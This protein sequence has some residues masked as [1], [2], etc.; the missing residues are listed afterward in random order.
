M[1]IT[2][3]GFKTASLLWQQQCSNLETTY[4]RHAVTRHTVVTVLTTGW[5]QFLSP[6]Q[7]NQSTGSQ[8][9]LSNTK[10]KITEQKNWKTCIQKIQKGLKVHKSKRYVVTVAILWPVAWWT[11]HP[12]YAES[13]FR[14]T[15]VFKK[16]KPTGFLGLYWVLGF[17]GYLW[18]YL[19]EQLG[20][21]LVD[22]AH[23]L[24]FYLRFASSLDYL[25]RSPA[26]ARMADRTAP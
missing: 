5:M 21:L 16:A 13:G 22:L 6:K 14:K 7:H 17:I 24:S 11:I 3:P 18:N 26:V 8:T 12:I 9:A 19:N 2:I 1:C 10:I 15:Q 25:T 4:C 23:Q 20:S